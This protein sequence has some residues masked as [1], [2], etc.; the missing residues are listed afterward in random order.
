MCL[1]YHSL[2]DPTSITY[3]LPY[4][5]PLTLLAHYPNKEVASGGKNIVGVKGQHVAGVTASC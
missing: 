5:V 3:V 1:V 4:I 2:Q